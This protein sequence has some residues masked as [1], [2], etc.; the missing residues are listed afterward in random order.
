MGIDG[1]Q[2]LEIRGAP[3]ILDQ[4]EASGIVFEGGAP[5]IAERFFGAAAEVRHRS[6]RHLVIRYE[7]RNRPVYEYL[8]QL[9]IAYPTLWI[10]ND[11]KTETGNCGLWIGRTVNGTPAIQELEWDELIIEEEM[12]GEDFSIHIYR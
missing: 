3:A 10:K 1:R 11:Y 7:Y 4:L 12:Q 2:Y 5:H 8:K 6:S 9:L